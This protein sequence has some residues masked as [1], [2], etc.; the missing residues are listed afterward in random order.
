M[1][2][3]C[4]LLAGC[5]PE[6]P[7]EAYRQ[8]SQEQARERMAQDDGHLIVD[9]R[10]LDE[11]ESGHIPGAI[12]IPNESI[13]DTRPEE[14]THPD[15]PLLIYCRT[16][17]RSKQAAEKLA[18]LGYTA[19]YEFGGIVDWTGEIVTGQ[20]LLLS[21]ESNPTTGYSW[22]LEQEGAA[23]DAQSVYVAAPQSAPVSGAGGR[24]SFLL[25]PKAPGETLLRFTYS[26]PWEKNESDAQLSLRVAISEDEQITVLDDSRTEWEAAGY[27][28]LLKIY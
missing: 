3:S 24:Q 5:A 2:L 10:R 20:S 7:K 28:P 12:C 6:A 13:G 25:T 4:L 15:Q 14:L 9:V 27:A 17:N 18:R 16:G 26:R 19:V 8:I 11:Y 21:V 1:L 22:T 23:F